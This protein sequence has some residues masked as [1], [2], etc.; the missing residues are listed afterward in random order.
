MDFLNASIVPPRKDEVTKL[1]LGGKYLLN[2]NFSLG[3]DYVY[4]QRS[5]T[6]EDQDYNRHAFMVRLGAQW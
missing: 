3:A 6:A 2:R 5:T 4:D 1:T